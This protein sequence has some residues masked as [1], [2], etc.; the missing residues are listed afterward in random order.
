MRVSARGGGFL[1]PRASRHGGSGGGERRRRRRRRGR[2]REGRWRSRS[3]RCDG[4]SGAEGF[5]GGRP[6]EP[7]LAPRPPA[8]PLG[9]AGGLRAPCCCCQGAQGEPGTLSTVMSPGPE[10]I[11][12]ISSSS[13]SS[14]SNEFRHHHEA[15]TA[16]TQL[17]RGAVRR[18][19]GRLAPRPGLG[20]RRQVGSPPR[21]ARRWAAC[22]KAAAQHCL[23]CPPPGSE[24]CSRRPRGVSHVTCQRHG[25]THHACLDLR[26]CHQVRSRPKSRHT[27]S[28]GDLRQSLT[29]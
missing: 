3:G 18:A 13:S 4:G 10:D 25:V 5:G 19:A 26:Q 15:D 21:A 27:D 1:R 12:I 14:S 17:G 2:R 11:I 6:P 22:L 23:P 24:P 28:D 7:S 20:G 9:T 29:E 16:R 8:A